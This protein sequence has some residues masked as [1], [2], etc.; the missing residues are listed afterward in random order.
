M[1]K[2]VTDGTLIRGSEVLTIGGNAYIFTDIKDD[3]GKARME[4]DYDE[5]GKYNGCSIA[6]DAIQLSGTIRSRTDKP[7]PP[8]FVTFSR[9][10]VNYFIFD[11]E[12]SG[13]TQGLKQFAVSIIQQ[14]AAALVI[15]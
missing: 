13:S 11:R 5:L 14:K 2:V 7:D 6:E 3:T 1:D 9:G 15:S 12:F 8:K 10:G 4:K